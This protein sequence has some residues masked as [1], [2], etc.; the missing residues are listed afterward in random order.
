MGKIK[1][2]SSQCI[3]IPKRYTSGLIFCSFTTL[4]WKFLKGEIVARIG[5]Q[6]GIKKADTF[7]YP[8]FIFFIGRDY[9][10]RTNG[11]LLPKQ[12]L[13]QAELS[14][15][16]VPAD[17]KP[18]TLTHTIINKKYFCK[19]FFIGEEKCRKSGLCTSRRK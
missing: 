1:A 4:Y 12:A 11:I 2:P 9:W 10:I 13:Y 6:N 16:T 3:L 5:L 7:Q 8:F 19:Q 14:P 15:E 18:P 17:W